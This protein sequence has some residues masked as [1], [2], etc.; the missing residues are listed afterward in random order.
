VHSVRVQLT[1]M[2]SA[3]LI[4]TV[5]VLKAHLMMAENLKKD[6]SEGST[7]NPAN[8]KSA[9]GGMGSSARK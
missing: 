8:N 3:L 6:I 4:Y 5:P 1:S 7:K 9:T 2:A